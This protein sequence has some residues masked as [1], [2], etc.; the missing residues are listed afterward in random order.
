MSL[1]RRH[2]V[3]STSQ[4]ISK[5]AGAAALLGSTGVLPALAQT[6][7]T[8]SKSSE[9]SP[10]ERARETEQKMTDDERFSLIVSLIGA[11]PSVG[12]PGDR[13]SPEG[14]NMSAGYTPGIR[15]L[16]VPAL[17]SSDASMGV[18]NPGYRPDDKGATA[19]PASIAVGSSFNPQLARE[20]GAAIGR[21]ARI[22]GFN[23][24]LAGGI[25]LARDPRNGRNF[26]YYSED[27]YHSAVL[28]AEQVNGIQSQGVISTLKHYTLNC[29]ETNRHWLDALIDPDAHRESDLL[30]F[31]IAIERSQPGSIMSGYNKIN[32]EYASGSHH[33]LNEVL[34]GAWGYQGYVMSDWARC[35][36]GTMRSRGSTRNPASSST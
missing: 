19:F 36:S 3:V 2:F 17:Q 12:R 29:N 1:T 8:E 11:V 24:M 21:E 6:T 7:S 14:V 30:T 25:N 31:Q 22:R 34:K 27:P 13:R 32:G 4:Q 16:G 9:L 35:P 15:R 28:A 23:I 5:L 10:D 18:T 20:G 26:E 33:L